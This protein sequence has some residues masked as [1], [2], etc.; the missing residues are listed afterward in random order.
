MVAAPQ[1]ATFQFIGATTGK[2]Y[3]VD[4]YLSDVANA[5]VRFDGGAG[6][7]TG[8][9]V[10]WKAPEKVILVDFAINTGMTDTTVIRI[11]VN[12]RPLSQ[13]LRYAQH[14]NT[15][16]T[17]PAISVGIN[18]QAEFGAIQLA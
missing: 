15:I 16:A 7:G 18:S 8:S 14:V 12:G 6:S 13:M 11:T 10:Y 4:A 9:P 5:N 1:Y 3:F 2:S 17:R